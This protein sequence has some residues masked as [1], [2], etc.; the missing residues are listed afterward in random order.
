MDVFHT[1][2]KLSPF[3][4]VSQDYQT[5]AF[6]ENVILGNDVIFKCDIPS[7]MSDFVRVEAWIDSEAETYFLGQSYGKKE[8]MTVHPSVWLHCCS[9]IKTSTFQAASFPRCI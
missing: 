9:L 4:A 5:D 8:T 6:R 2:V 1:N 3:P 7:F